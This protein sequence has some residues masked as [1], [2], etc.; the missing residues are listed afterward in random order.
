MTTLASQQIDAWMAMASRPEGEL[1]LLLAYI[2]G[3]KKARDCFYWAGTLPPLHLFM[4]RPLMRN[5]ERMSRGILAPL[6]N[7]FTPPS[8][9]PWGGREI[10]RRYKT[11]LG[12][13]SE[14]VV[15]ESW[16]LSSH[17]SFPNHFA[18]SYAGQELAV[19]IHL[20]EQLFPENLYGKDQ[21]SLP[22][23][24]K[25]L[26]TGSWKAQVDKL[27]SSAN[28]NEIYRQLD[29]ND[30]K[31]QEML[32]SILS[33]QVHPNKLGGLPS[34]TEAWLILEAEEGAGIY[35]GLKEGVQKAEFQEALDSGQDLSVFLNF[36]EVAPGDVYFIPAGTLH[37][38]GAG[39]LLL[40]PQESS[41]TTFRVYDWN[42]E[43][44]GERR[45]L[46]G[47][48]AMI[49]TDWDASRGSKLIKELRSQAP[50]GEGMQTLVS[51]P[52]FNLSSLSL[53]DSV[54]YQ[55]STKEKVQ[56]F[57]V[58]KGQIQVNAKETRSFREGESF[59]LPAAFGEYTI[60]AIEKDTKIIMTE[61]GDRNDRS[62]GIS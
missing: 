49:A 20:L 26:N 44:N 5:L 28:Y 61:K 43:I 38:I 39:L 15:G 53:K 21:K 30:P 55:H 41:E 24:Q 10:I 13:S 19:P 37:A 46:H 2:K 17:Q 4:Q 36:V 45:T 60:E 51:C 59:L 50:D 47:K 6:G 11:K 25:L 42:R 8:R 33:V 40:E 1:K 35:L 12:Y 58:Q 62:R 3:T 22:F 52:E 18:F 48:E 7:N 14:D 31:T 57:F 56:G 9:T 16:E 54:S 32:N 23:L 34:K 29:R 27:N